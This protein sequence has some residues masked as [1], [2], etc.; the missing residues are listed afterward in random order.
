MYRK[1]LAGVLTAI[2]VAAVPS[3]AVTAP[4]SG[5]A[6]GFSA[7]VTNPYYP[8]LPGMRWEYRGE[9]GRASCRERV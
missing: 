4:A 8:L 5:A 2:A 9:I 1:V 6:G 7:R 3:P